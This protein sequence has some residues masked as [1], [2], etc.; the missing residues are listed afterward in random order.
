[1]VYMIGDYSLEVEWITCA[2]RIQH[3]ISS[4]ENTLMHRLI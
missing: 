2:M 4:T 1:M 3:Q